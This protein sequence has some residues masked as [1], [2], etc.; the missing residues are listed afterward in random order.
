MYMRGQRRERERERE[1]EEE[2]AKKQQ[3]KSKQRH[4]QK[5]QNRQDRQTDNVPQTEMTIAAN[6][7]HSFRWLC[8]EESLVLN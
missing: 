4:G 5:K 6:R 7:L 2:K 1:R 8:K 3:A